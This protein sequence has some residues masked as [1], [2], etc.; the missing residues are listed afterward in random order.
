MNTTRN[1]PKPET[2]YQRS[3]NQS[4]RNGTPIRRV[5]F[6]YTTSRSLE[7]TVSWF[8]NPKSQV[9]AH[10]TVG[11]DGRIVQMVKDEA[12]AWHAGGANTDS[13]GIEFCAA[14]G[15][16][17]TPEQEVSG[18]ALV[19]YL[20]EEYHLGVGAFW[21]HR[22]LPSTTTGT[23]CPGSLWSSLGEL[24]T[25]VKSALGEKPSEPSNKPYAPCPVP[26]PWTVALGL[27]ANCT[28]AGKSIYHLQCAL[29][30][31]GYLRGPANPAT[32]VGDV[33]NE[34]VEFAVKSFQKDE[35]LDAD[36]I[37]GLLTR[38]AL[39]TTLLRVRTVSERLASWE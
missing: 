19:R 8:L 31:L 17:L 1:A 4:S 13:I 24:H 38:K 6:H 11:R 5:V 32:M 18:K 3:P 34:H 7:G 23:D 30:G 37:V 2:S 27:G 33:F 26:L 12:K 20:A 35:G 16:K 21:G 28:S 36:G 29:I 14:K 39:Q 9:S 22:F 25:W 15:D 10:Y